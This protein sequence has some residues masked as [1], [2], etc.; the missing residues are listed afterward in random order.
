MSSNKR[1][2][3]EVHTHLLEEECLRLM[4]TFQRRN[5]LGSCSPL[6]GGNLEIHCSPLG[7]GMLEFHAPDRW[8]ND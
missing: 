1:R 5:A 4:P 3:L 7:R 6:G 2:M 8:R